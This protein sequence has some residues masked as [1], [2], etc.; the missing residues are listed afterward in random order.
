MLHI[1]TQ[2]KARQ[3]I[4]ISANRE[5]QP[6]MFSINELIKDTHSQIHVQQLVQQST[7]PS[8]C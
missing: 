5:E 4:A 6:T 1:R 3:G 2:G 8:C 7:W